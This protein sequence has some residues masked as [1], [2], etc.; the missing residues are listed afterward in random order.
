MTA[1]WPTAHQ[2]IMA[3]ASPAIPGP[4]PPPLEPF[5]DF[6]IRGSDDPAKIDLELICPRCDG[7][8]CDVEDRDTLGLLARCAADHLATCA[9]PPGAGPPT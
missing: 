4:P 8:V 5:E 7:V 3:G 9:A 6:E 1:L 2:A